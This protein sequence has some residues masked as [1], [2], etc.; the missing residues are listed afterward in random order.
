MNANDVSKQL[1]IPFVILDFE[2]PENLLKSYKILGEIFGKEKEADEFIKYYTEKM[3]QIKSDLAVVT[4]EK[5]KSVY[6]GQRK[7]NP[8]TW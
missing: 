7:T 6:L 4:D 1:G 3:N 8:D 2:T 5:K